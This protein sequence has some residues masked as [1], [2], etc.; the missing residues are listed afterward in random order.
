MNS[1]I[2]QIRNVITEECY[3]GSAIN[4]HNRWFEHKRALRKNK[5]CNKH[6]QNAWNKYNEESF[7][8]EIIE[9]VLNKSN[10]IIKEQYYLDLLKPEYNICQIAGSTTGAAF[11][12]S[13]DF[14][15]KQSIS[16]KGKKRSD[17]SKR[18]QSISM[19]GNKSNTGLIMPEY[20]RKKISIAN[21]GKKHS[22]EWNDK[23]SKSRLGIEPWNKGLHLQN[24]KLS[25]I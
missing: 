5:H 25:L 4:F 2:Y 8:F 1:G 11:Y 10:L 19:L 24:R 16:H 20:V 7:I 17:E 18:K 15:Q 6:L 22:K 21:K 23:I 13:K 3:I 9:E 12:D 14:R